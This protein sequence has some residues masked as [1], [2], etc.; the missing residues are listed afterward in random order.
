MAGRLFLRVKRPHAPL[1]PSNV[2][3][4]CAFLRDAGAAADVVR[5]ALS[6]GV[7]DFDVAPL[8]GGGRMERYLGA[9]IAALDSAADRDRVRVFTKVGRLLT[10]DDGGGGGGGGVEN[11]Y[12]AAGLAR[13]LRASERRL[14]PAGAARISGLKIHDPNDSL[15]RPP[16]LDEVGVALGEGGICDAL[17]ALRDRGGGGGGG[18][19]GRVIASV[20]IGMNTNVE[21]T[22][23][24]GGVV[25]LPPSL[26][27]GTPAEVVRM[28]KGKPRGSY[29]E[30]LLA[31]GW[32]LLSQAGLASLVCCQKRG[33]GA[34]VAGVFSTG[35]LVGV[36]QY[37]YQVA[38]PDLVA[39]AKE[40]G[41]LAE[42]YGMT[43][44]EVALAFA[45]LPECATKVVIGCATADEV[46]QNV[47]AAFRSSEVA[48][49]LWDAAKDKGLLPEDLF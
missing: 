25:A 28:L 43:L 39:R 48:H 20:G 17:I 45:F 14:G 31:G 36:E 40:W 15:S 16:G 27:E 6:Y 22:E 24:A 30:A 2:V 38:P 10:D 37:A 8:Y 26:S 1:L 5:A 11:D 21:K 3:I 4:G 7:T 47:E 18:G 35:L 46:V 41:A 9:G 12:T 23:T 44:P 34:A 49:G 42:A 29:D 32:T 19:G 13:S 33:V